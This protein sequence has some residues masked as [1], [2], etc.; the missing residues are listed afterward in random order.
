MTGPDLTRPRGVFA[1]GTAGTQS[2]G[3]SG[4]GQRVGDCA[5]GVEEG[6]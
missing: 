4:C 6:G 3:C 1:D 2:L 5:G